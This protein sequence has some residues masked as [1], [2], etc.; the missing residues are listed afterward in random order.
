MDQGTLGAKGN[1]TVTESDE[2]DLKV[3]RKEF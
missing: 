1:K 3:L 2:T